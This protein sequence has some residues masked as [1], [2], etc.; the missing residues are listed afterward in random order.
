MDVVYG[1]PAPVTQRSV[2]FLQGHKRNQ[3]KTVPSDFRYGQWFNLKLIYVSEG[4][5]FAQASVSWHFSAVVRILIHGRDQK[6]NNR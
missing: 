3:L 2:P 6:P 1:M 4:P 5:V